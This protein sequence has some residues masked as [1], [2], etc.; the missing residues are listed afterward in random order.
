MPINP[1]DDLSQP[2]RT[3]WIG[4]ETRP[5]LGVSQVTQ[6][7]VV[8]GLALED[9]HC[10]VLPTVNWSWAWR[11]P[12]KE[13]LEERGAMPGLGTSGRK[14]DKRPSGVRMAQGRSC[15]SS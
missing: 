9:G 3:H 5:S 10:P 11:E 14:W 7:S 15:W 4:G 12:R 13:T 6:V 8:P 1:W 2:H